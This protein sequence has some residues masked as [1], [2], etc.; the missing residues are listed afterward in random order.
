MNRPKVVLIVEDTADGQALR[1]LAEKLRLGIVLDYLPA[2]G[3]GE[4]KRRGDMLIRQAK[5]RIEDDNG[6]VAV[7]IDRDSQSPEHVKRNRAIQQHCRRENVPLLLAI[8]EL[9][10]WFIADAGCATWLG[11]SRPH[12]SDTVAD[13]KDQVRRAYRKKTGKSYQQRKAR[14]RLAQH[15][16]GSG[17]ERSP[18]MKNALDHL[19]KS[20]CMANK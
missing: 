4:I 18:S 6:C 16:D 1:H 11:L 17:P 3:T 19:E 15:C 7:L 20:P 5:D 2:K 12:N 14:I 10:A 13:P 8:E 9:E